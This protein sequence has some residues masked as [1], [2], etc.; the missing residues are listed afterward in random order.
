[1]LRSSSGNPRL[2]AI[3]AITHHSATDSA[4][5]V[6]AEGTLA[7]EMARSAA[8]ARSTPSRPAPHCWIRRRPAIRSIEFRVDPGHRRNQDRCLGTVVTQ[9]GGFDSFNDDTWKRQSQML[10]E[11]G[12]SRT[13]DHDPDVVMKH[14][15]LILDVLFTAILSKPNS[16]TE[17]KKG[18][19]NEDCAETGG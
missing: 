3:A 11:S 19:A 8:A 18:Y 5:P 1:M 9:D 15:L 7:T 13:R 6:P 16:C 14:D 12:E 17:N 4:L 2:R 10:S